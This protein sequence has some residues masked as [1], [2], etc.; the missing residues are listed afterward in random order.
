MA[1]INDDLT[2]VLARHVMKWDIGVD[3]FLMGRRKWI[4]CWRFQPMERLEDAFRLLEVAAPQEYT[5]SREGPGPFCVRVRISGKTGE[6]R[7][8]SMPRAIS[9]AVSRALQI[10][11]D[12]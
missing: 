6:A 12:D 7:D 3:R 4:P 9:L 10:Q 11:V 5:M 2:N 1:T 8:R